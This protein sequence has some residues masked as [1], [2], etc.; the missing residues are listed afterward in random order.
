M[1]IAAELRRII[2]AKAA[3][4]AAII[5]KG[6]EVPDTDKIDLYHEYIDQISAGG[7]Y[8]PDI[9]T[10]DNLKKAVRAGDYSTYPLGTEIPD[11]IGDVDAPWIVVHYGEATLPDGSTTTGA[12]LHRKYTSRTGVVWSPYYTAYSTSSVKEYLD[13]AYLDGCSQDLKDAITE[14]KIKC[15]FG[16]ASTAPQ[17]IN[18]KVFLPSC[19]EL[20]GVPATYSSGQEGQAWDY[21]K[22]GVGTPTAAAGATTPATV[23]VKNDGTSSQEKIWWTRTLYTGSNNYVNVIWNGGRVGQAG[24]SD[25]T[26]RIAPACFIGK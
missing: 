26:N 3:I 1:T 20:W 16:S 10:L 21:Y 24:A 23:R 18:A 19:S 5:E 14:I 7:G 2:D 13:G 12:Y 4:R 15:V 6:V 8:D 25:S 9:S 11:K 17:E 22:N